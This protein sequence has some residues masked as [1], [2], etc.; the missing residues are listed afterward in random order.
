MQQDCVYTYIIRARVSLWCFERRLRSLCLERRSQLALLL[1]IARRPVLLF[2][3]RAAFTAATAARVARRGRYEHR[4]AR[5]G[6]KID[7]SVFAPAARPFRALS[8]YIYRARAL[9]RLPL[10][11]QYVCVQCACFCV[12]GRWI[13]YGIIWKCFLI[14]RCCTQRIFFF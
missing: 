12:W 6:L 5:R 9:C 7:I 4:T 8:P 10:L 1:R 11:S 3:S 14:F 2:L 13:Y